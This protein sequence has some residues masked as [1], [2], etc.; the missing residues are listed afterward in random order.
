MLTDTAA[1]NAKPKP[2]AYKL[3][4]SGGLHL[5][6]APTGTKSWRLK[7]RVGGVE[8]QVVLGR[9][10][11]VGLK[12]ARE[13]RNWTKEQIS[14][15][16]DP[17]ILKKLKLNQIGGD[18]SFEV[19]ARRWYEINQGK[20]RDRHREDVIK[21][22]E[23]DVF[24]FMGSVH[25]DAINEDYLLAI[26]KKIEGRG[27]IETA[28]RVRQ[29]C[30]RI[31]R[32]AK[33]LRYTKNNP[34][35]DLGELLSPIIKTR[36]WPAMLKVED[37]R[38]LIET[39]DTAAASPVTRLASRFLAL[40]AQRPGMVH[41]AE[42]KEFDFDFRGGRTPETDVSWT[43]PAEKMKQSL[44]RRESAEFDHVVPLSAA[45]VE[46]LVAVQTLT[47]NGAFVFPSGRSSLEPMS[48]NALSFI[49]KREGYKGRH[50]PHGWRASFSTIMNGR[51]ER[52]YTGLDRLV[53]ERLIIDLMLAHLPTGVSATELIYN[54]G[55]Y[56][57]R[58]RELASEWAELLMEGQLPAMALLDGP[59]RRPAGL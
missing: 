57:E 14:A 42:W 50:V 38:Q 3:F 55:G 4:D 6:V 9:Y 17:S 23:R 49:Y 29:R 43:I 15:G 20:W 5:F 22:L 47:G 41:L 48:E 45:S 18:H 35:T 52:A 11:A 53:V 2:K 13:K 51:V 12:E 36:R 1:R 21:S 30:E 19:L 10:P 16:R 56:K 7:Y 54:R 25:I 37:L 26:L 44:V 34:A 58:R 33:V 28:H 59:R 46:V 24:P 32:M 27:A 31:F 8:N 40:T 39:I